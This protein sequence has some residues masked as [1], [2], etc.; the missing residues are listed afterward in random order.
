[1]HD[2][3]FRLPAALTIYTVGETQHALTAW[4]STLPPEATLWRIDAA[5]I[6]EADAAGVELLLSISRSAS[7]AGARLRLEAPSPALRRASEQLGSAP[8]VL[9]TLAPEGIA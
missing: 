1:M 4:L 8:I 3:A 5:G 2:A 6:E 7:L 9:G